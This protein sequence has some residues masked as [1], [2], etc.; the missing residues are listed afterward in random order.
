MFGDAGAVV[1]RVEVALLKSRRRP[2][3][4]VVCGNEPIVVVGRAG[5]LKQARCASARTSYGFSRWLSCA[6]IAAGRFLPRHYVRGGSDDEPESVRSIPQAPPF[7][8][9]SAHRAATPVHRIFAAQRQTSFL[10]SVSR[11]VST[12][13][14]IGLCSKEQ[15]DATHS[16]R[17]PTMALICAYF[18]VKSAR[19]TLRPLIKPAE[20]SQSTGRR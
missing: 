17:L 1:V 13:R 3:I 20:S 12:L 4:S 9:C 6:V 16:A 11:R 8:R 15:E 7:R 5:S 2:R 14:S 19:Q 10:T 18:S